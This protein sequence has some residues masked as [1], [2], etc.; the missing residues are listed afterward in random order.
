MIR[1]DISKQLRSAVSPVD[2]RFRCEFGESEFWTVFGKS[3]VG[4]TT[5]LRLCAGLLDRQEGKIENSFETQSIAFQDPRLLPWKN[6]VDNISFGLKAMGV[7]PK[8][9]EGGFRGGFR[10]RF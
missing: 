10:S 9:R 6:V 2:F 5:L 8:K 3:G 1:I 7:P 4:K